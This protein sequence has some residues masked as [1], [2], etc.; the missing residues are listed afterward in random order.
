MD[1]KG[2]KLRDGGEKNAAK[3]VSLQARNKKIDANEPTYTT[4][5]YNTY[6]QN[7]EKNIYDHPKTDIDCHMV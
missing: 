5:E 4:S 6:C 2:V 1:S 3:I 7:V